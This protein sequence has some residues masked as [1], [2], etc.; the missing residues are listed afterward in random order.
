[1]PFFFKQWGGAQKERKGHVLHGRTYNEFPV[2]AR[3]GT[4][5][6]GQLSLSLR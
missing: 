4:E 3:I 2:T 6:G 1:V 5:E